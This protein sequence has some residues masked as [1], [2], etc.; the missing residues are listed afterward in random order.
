M[1]TFQTCCGLLAYEAITILNCIMAEVDWDGHDATNSLGKKGAGDVFRAS[2]VAHTQVEPND[3]VLA[4][5]ALAIEELGKVLL[6][7]PGL[8]EVLDAVAQGFRVVLARDGGVRLV[9]SRVVW[10]EKGESRTLKCMLLLPGT[11]S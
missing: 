10:R 8:V 6:G 7:L 11:M 1:R 9:E 4:V 3:Q 5:D 2:K